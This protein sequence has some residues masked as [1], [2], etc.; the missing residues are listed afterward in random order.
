[1]LTITNT[2]DLF[3]LPPPVILAA[4]GFVYHEDENYYRLPVSAA[5]SSFI[6]TRGIRRYHTQQSG[7]V[8]Y[9]LRFVAARHQR[10]LWHLHLCAGQLHTLITLLRGGHGQ[11]KKRFYARSSQEAVCQPHEIPNS[12]ARLLDDSNRKCYL[13]ESRLTK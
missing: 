8:L 3:K 9:D 6:Y 11:C 7:A 10:H 4:L 2:T 5:G 13:L 12:V 1:M